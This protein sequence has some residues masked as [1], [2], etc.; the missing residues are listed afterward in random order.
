MN[1]LLGSA[2][3]V[4]RLDLM[5]V[6]SHSLSAKRAHLALV[7]QLPST[8]HHDDTIG[9]C[10]PRLPNSL[11][12]RARN[13]DPLLLLL[14][15]PCRDLESARNEL[16]WLREYAAKIRTPRPQG[17]LTVPPT[18][19]DLCRSRATGRPLQYIVG[20]QPFGELSI[21]CR[22]GVL[23]PRYQCTRYLEIRAKALRPETEN[24]TTH[25][26]N[27]LVKN[28]SALTR[29]P[30]DQRFR[31]LDLCSGTGCISLLLYARLA[32][33]IPHLRV[34]GY[35]I[36]PKAIALAIR[37]LKRNVS[38]GNLPQK[39]SWQVRYRTLD[40]TQP[41]LGFKAKGD[42][43]ISNPPYILPANF[44]TKISR[45]VRAF[46]PRKAL[47]SCP[48]SVGHDSESEADFFHS[49][50]LKHSTRV[51]TGLL[52]MEVGDHAQAERIVPKVGQGYP[53]NIQA[54]K[55]RS[56]RAFEGGEL[57][58]DNLDK[59]PL[60]DLKVDW[61]A[62]DEESASLK[63]SLAPEECLSREEPGPGVSAHPG[64]VNTRVVVLWKARGREWLGRTE[65]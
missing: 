14:L 17:S 45:S 30:N 36:E 4:P 55:K 57:W 64:S 33:Y 62:K 19:Y 65:G 35:D 49:H 1:Y 24:Y 5:V 23:I 38:L 21:L 32:P 16:R 12:R 60:N 28:A 47:V 40:I 10:M 22:P 43:I 46:E 7:M 6:T 56:A 63:K 51:R 61:R 53:S 42:I 59:T 50:V 8:R 37:N 48:P 34:T 11:L 9:E 13:I 52:L 2:P 29:S 18:L 3:C 41:P 15:R 26:A 25:L 31:I 44:S 20:D 54:G 27:L 58:S 39:A